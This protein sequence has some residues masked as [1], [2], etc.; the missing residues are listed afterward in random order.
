MNLHHLNRVMFFWALLVLPGNHA[1]AAEISVY[2][3]CLVVTISGEIDRKTPMLLQRSLDAHSCKMSETGS[4]WFTLDSPGGDLDAAIKTGRILRSWQATVLVQDGAQC[5]SACVLVLLGGVQRIVVSGNIGLHRPYSRDSS[6]SP[7]DA[8]KKY[9]IIRAKLQSYFQE[10]N[11]PD[12][13]LDAMN[14][15]SPHQTRWLSGQ[16]DEKE[17]EELW[18]QGRDP[19]WED[20]LLS[21]Q[22]QELDISK[23]EYINR[24]QRARAQ[25]GVSIEAGQNRSE[26]QRMFQNEWECQQRIIKGHYP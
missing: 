7:D 5:A 16:R 22:A 17:L 25:C 11:I 15:V 14:A 18:I 6:S 19:V 2:E 23:Q 20:V 12:R 26:M 21:R 24:I 4:G 1:D 13:L 10:M 8:A 3:K 9:R